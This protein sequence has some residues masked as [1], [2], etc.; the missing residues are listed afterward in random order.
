MADR[1]CLH[2]V[3]YLLYNDIVWQLLPPELGFGSG[4]TCWRRLE[5][6]QQAGVF[7]QRL[8]PPQL[9]ELGGGR[10]EQAEAVDDGVRD[11]GGVGVVRPAVVGVVVPLA[12]LDVVGQRLGTMPE[13]SP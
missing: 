2:G 10:A 7:D 5:R 11:E 12:G 4:Q 3:L 13:C 9:V 6:W 8:E 1:L